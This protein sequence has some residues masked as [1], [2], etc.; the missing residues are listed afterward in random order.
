MTDATTVTDR[1]SALGLALAEAERERDDEREGR[2]TN[3]A[4]LHAAESELAEAEGVLREIAVR[5][6]EMTQPCPVVTDC[7][8]LWCSECIAR[9]FLAREVPHA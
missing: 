7:P 5:R 3:L 1:E 6:C 2:V 8:A 9:A 4:R